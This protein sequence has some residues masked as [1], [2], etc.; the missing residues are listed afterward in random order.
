M[1]DNIIEVKNLTKIYNPRKNPVHAL[2]EIS[3]SV[4]RGEIF[5]LL[6][7]NGAGKSTTLNI[8]VGLLTH[9][10]GSVYI[11]GKNFFT[12][13]E[14]IKQR[15]NIATAYADLGS[16]L[17]VQQNLKVYAGMYGIKNSRA[18][19]DTL[20]HEFEA[21]NFRDEQFSQLSAGQK[22]RANLCKA[23]LNDPDVL[24]LDEPTASLDPSI[25]ARTR[26]LLLQIQ[27]E[28]QITILF[29]SHNMDE[30]QQMCDRVALLHNGE[31]YMI[32]TP[33]NLVSHHEALDL[34]DVFIRLAKGEFE[35]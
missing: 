22:T 26:G 33:A 16:N 11:F 7:V 28:R 15:M 5:G 35:E 23:L 30:V 18:R 21:D 6:G 17:T 19:I 1:A 8:L 25:A 13:D 14:E 24:L 12:H 4:R 29:T 2:K 34:E 27:K 10:S 31:I 9:T 32:D 20:L 3:F